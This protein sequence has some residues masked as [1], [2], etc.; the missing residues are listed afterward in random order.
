[1]GISCRP[2][3]QEEVMRDT[4]QRQLEE[5][6][7]LQALVSQ[8]DLNDSEICWKG[9]KAEYSSQ[10]SFWSALITSW[11]SWHS[12]SRNWQAEALLE[13]S[14]LQRKPDLSNAL[15]RVLSIW[16]LNIF[17][18]ED[19]LMMVIFLLIYRCNFF[20]SN[21]CPLSLS[22]RILMKRLPVFSMANV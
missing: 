15:S 16:I 18:E 7:Y 20:W 6:L 13:K 10:G 12:W 2:L 8:E 21:L 4:S 17:S 1:M 3:D 5:A 19:V 22:P 11:P 14:R 9:K